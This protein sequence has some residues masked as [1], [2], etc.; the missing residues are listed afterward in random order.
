MVGKVTP[1][2]IPKP[3]GVLGWDGTDFWAVK[4]DTSGR[5]CV[6]GSD[7]LF[8]FKAPVHV[9]TQAVI[10]GAGGYIE[11]SAVPAGE[12]WVLQRMLARDTTTATTQHEYQTNQAGAVLRFAIVR[13]T[14]VAQYVTETVGE[15]YLAEGDKVRVT[16]VGG[17]AADTCVIWL[18]GYSMTKE[19]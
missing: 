14:F 19:A 5:L 11:S 8:S 16:F 1:I 6:R 18:H 12:I 3:V 9:G 7:Q 15:L 2:Y 4:V 17:A 13:G 10:S